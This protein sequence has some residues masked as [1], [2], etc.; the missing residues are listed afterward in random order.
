MGLVLFQLLQPV[1]TGN[2]CHERVEV[3]TFNSYCP[4]STTYVI[5]APKT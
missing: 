3:I 1:N 2:D 4:S 5:G